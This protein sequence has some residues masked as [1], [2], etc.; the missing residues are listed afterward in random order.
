MTGPSSSFFSHAP[1]PSN[2]V[3]ATLSEKKVL[4][5]FLFVESRQVD[6][7]V[8]F[9]FAATLAKT[10]ALSWSRNS[11]KKLKPKPLDLWELSLGLNIW[12]IQLVL[13]LWRNASQAPLTLFKTWSS[14][15]LNKTYAH[16]KLS[17]LYPTGDLSICRFPVSFTFILH[18]T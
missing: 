6:T 1:S 7:V 14:R 17:I 8:K 2:F 10:F 11:E 3:I 9:K 15:S 5:V 16:F 13:N 18:N 12:K 4:I